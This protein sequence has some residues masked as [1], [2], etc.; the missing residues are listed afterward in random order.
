[1]NAPLT[2][3]TD[4]ATER[5]RD[6][7]RSEILDGVFQPG[8]RLKIVEIAARYGI[9]PIPVREAM[10][11]LAGEGLIEMI[12]H[13]GAIV[14]QVDRAFIVDMYDIRVALEGML[15]ERA[16]ERM[17]PA[18][19]KQ[20][21][22]AAADYA[23]A[24]NKLKLRALA[25]ANAAFHNA[26]NHAADNP[27]AVR[28]VD[29]STTMIRAM[30][31]RIGMSAE[32]AAIN[33]AQHAAIVEALEARD[34]ARAAAAVRIHCITGRDDLLAHCDAEPGFSARTVAAGA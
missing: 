20:I 16:I 28:M 13:R 2:V 8:E 10:R 15:A 17:R 18:T 30:R 6:R 23:K 7:M 27:E 33:V 26:I 5:V 21:R 9:S 25:E 29:G 12:A 31:M 32:R 1:M 4:T 11:L 14:R 19:L 3:S 34:P 24:A 22:A